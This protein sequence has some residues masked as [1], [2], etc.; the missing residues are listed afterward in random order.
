M[1]VWDGAAALGGQAAALEGE[2][3][4]HHYYDE[5]DPARQAEHSRELTLVKALKR[6]MSLVCDRANKISV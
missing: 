5:S 1:M 4:E 2:P 3:S 6:A